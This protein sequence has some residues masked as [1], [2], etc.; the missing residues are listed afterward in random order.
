MIMG[1]SL[2]IVL[3]VYVLGIDTFL[4]LD[5]MEEQYA[6]LVLG[7]GLASVWYENRKW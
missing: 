1:L 3:L 6:F 4:G 5:I 7:L 2:T